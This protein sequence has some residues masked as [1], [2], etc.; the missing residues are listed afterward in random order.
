MTH[1]NLLLEI[2]IRNGLLLDAAGFVGLGL[3]GLAAVRLSTRHGSWG[4]TMIALGVIGLLA[5]R[6]QV[7]LTPH[8][9]TRELVQVIGPAGLALSFGSTQ[10]L[11]CFGLTLVVWG[12]WG[13][14]RW[15]NGETKALG[16]AIR[17]PRCRVSGR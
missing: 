2:A 7:F 15:M 3:A 13:H 6:M 5:A 1:E 17:I 11:L 8:V 10:I 9:L 16:G 14:H 12:I 4:G